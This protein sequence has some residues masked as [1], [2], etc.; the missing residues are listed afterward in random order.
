MRHL[1]ILSLSLCLS[2]TA[3]A[4]RVPVDL[5]L[6]FVVDASGSIDD[7]EFRLQ[8]QGYAEAL[9]NPD[10]QRAISGGFLRSVAVTY[11][12]FAGSGCIWQR[13]DWVRVHDVASA[14][15]V[16]DAILAAP[17]EYCSGGNAIG[18]AV[19]TAAESALGNRFEG[20]R[21]V[22]DVS[23]DGPDTAGF[24]SIEEA[25]AA[26]L[27]H[28]F[29]INGLVIERPSMPELPLYYR[30]A[31]IGGPRSFAI[32]AGSR[33]TFAEAIVQKLVLEIV[34]R[35]PSDTSGKFA[36]RIIPNP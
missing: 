34:D 1:V 19:A 26:A 7:E 28:G 8:R 20:T 13:V 21:K 6:A 5:E 2:A 3:W 33:A 29:T 11:V 16:G 23:G 25:R 36:F 18:E 4:Q 14:K 35:T 10:V 17:R 31:I 9:V 27:A 12:E 15:A 22:I 32:E 24:I 30:T